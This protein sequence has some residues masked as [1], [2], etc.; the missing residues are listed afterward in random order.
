MAD[1]EIPVVDAVGVHAPGDRRDPLDQ[2]TFQAQFALAPAA[3]LP[4]R[5]KIFQAL[6]ILQR[7][8]NDE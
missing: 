7:L 6:G 3:A 8:G 5:T 1:I 4:V 2:C